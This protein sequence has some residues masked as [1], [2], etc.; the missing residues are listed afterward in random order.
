[1]YNASKMFLL[2]SCSAVVPFFS[3]AQFSLSGQLRT[4]TEFRNGVGTLRAY[5]ASPSFFTSQRTRLSAGYQHSLVQFR[6]TVQDIRVW[7]QDAS[8]ISAADGA[9]LGVHEAWAE[10]VLQNR[11][12]SSRKI[13]KL[14][15]LGIRLGRQELVYDDARL[16]GNL[17]WL[18]QGRRHDALVLKLKEK[19]FAL[20]AGFAFSQNTDAFGYNGTYYTPANVAPTVRDSKGNLVASPAGFIPL[21]NAENISTRSGSPALLNPA[22]TNGVNQQ[23]KAMQFLHAAF[24][25]T[26]TSLSFLFLADHFSRRS[27]DSVRNIAGADTGYVYGWKFRTKGVHSRIT[28]GL[29]LSGALDQQKHWLYKAGYYFQGGHDKD[30]ASVSASILYASLSWQPTAFSFAVGYDLLSGND[31]FSTHSQN[32]RFDPLYGTP[33]KFWGY[34]DY[35]YV[36]TGSP[37]GGLSNPQAGIRYAGPKKKFSMSADYHAFFL[38]CDMKGK[39]SVKAQRYLGSEIDLSSVYQLNG[40]VSLEGGLSFLRA[41]RSMEYAKNIAPGTASLNASWAWLMVNIRPE[42]LRK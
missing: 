2:M 8:S 39:N 28:T 24:R 17:D 5:G 15:Y 30:G 10:L 25:K 35:F 42:F 27:L 32:H 21:V 20:D 4:R 18:Q 14:D 3:E 12:D 13:S 7:G 26:N 41:S 31:A 36:G 37:A 16:L 23:Y 33:H 19:N 6:L 11:S 40:F 9:R 29:Q 34:M 1:M 22:S 38:A